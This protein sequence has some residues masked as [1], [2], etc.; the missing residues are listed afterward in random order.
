MNSRARILNL[1]NGNS[2]MIVKE[3]VSVLLQRELVIFPT[4][5][6][7][8]IFGLPDP[9]VISKIIEVKDRDNKPIPVLF[10]ELSKVSEYFRIILPD[11]IDSFTDKFWPGPFTLILDSETEVPGITLNGSIG[12]RQP[13]YLPALEVISGAGGV[14]GVTSANISG[15]PGEDD[16]AKIE[17]VFR[18]KVGLI[19]RIPEVPGN[20]S[21]VIKYHKDSIEIMR[22]GKKDLKKLEDFFKECGLTMR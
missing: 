15:N 14:L 2:G 3:A 6:V 20:P 21:T 13:G 12:I 10:S 19:V 11:W 1:N 18:G 17:E 8:G 16:P 9:E 22:K 4:D 5:T 7:Y